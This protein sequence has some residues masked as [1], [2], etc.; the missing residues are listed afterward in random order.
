MV[1][2]IDLYNRPAPSPIE[3]V[4]SLL[5]TPQILV[6]YNVRLDPIDVLTDNINK[7]TDKVATYHLAIN[8]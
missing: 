7:I 2:G 3:E 4:S 1:E 5:E 6:I 8:L